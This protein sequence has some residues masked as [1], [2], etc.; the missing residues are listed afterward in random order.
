MVEQGAR[1]A[2]WA[3]RR[4]KDQDEALAAAKPKVEAAEALARCDRNMSI[5]DAAKHFGLYPRSQVFP[6]LREHGYLTT[7][8]IPTQAAIEAG[9]L[10]LRETEGN[11]GEIHKQAVVLVSQLD[12][13]RTKV[14]PQVRRWVNAE[15]EA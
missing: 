10:A 15:V 6:Y 1:F 4:I 12:T 5:T 11:D 14:A 9:Y 3:L 8:D 2:A 13:W 7:R